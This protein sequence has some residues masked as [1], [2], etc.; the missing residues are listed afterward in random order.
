MGLCEYLM[1]DKEEQWDELW[2]NGKFLV[3]YSS[4]DCKYCLYALYDFFVEVELDPVMD[5]IIGMSIFIGGKR[6][7]KYLDEFSIENL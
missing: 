7:E 1:L 5:N 4:I 6:L 2:D 3:N